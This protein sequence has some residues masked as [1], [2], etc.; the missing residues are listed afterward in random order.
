MRGKEKRKE[1]EEEEGASEAR[2]RAAHET[3]RALGFYAREVSKK[4]LSRPGKKR[5]KSY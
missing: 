3:G 5:G 4:L 1:A 2:E